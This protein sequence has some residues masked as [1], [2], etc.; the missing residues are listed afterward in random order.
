MKDTFLM[1]NFVLFI[2]S[3]LL[4]CSCIPNKKVVYFQDYGHSS[5][6]FDSLIRFNYPKYRLQKGDI[7][8]IDVRASDPTV[9]MIFDSNTNNN[10]VGQLAMGGADI[11]YLTGFPLNKN[12]DIELPL[13]GFV[14]VEGLSLE[15][16]KE[17]ISNELEKYIVEPYVIVRL[18]GIRYTALGEFRKPGRY[19]ILQSQLTIYE[20]LA[21]AGDL[22]I[23]ANRREVTIIRQYHDGQ[24]A[25]KI[26]LTDRNL[27]TSPFY[28]IQPN[29]QIYVEPLKVREIGAGVGVTGFG[30]ATSI[31]S[32]ISS[33][34]LI[35]VTLNN[36]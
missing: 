18:G 10:Q 5:V 7:L 2:I 19:A 14:K 28:Y 3:T 24:R 29:D 25:H 11:N 34:F 9:T 23:V 4:I 8:S 17:T 6:D 21:N 15:E 35:I 26:D 36:L 27:I 1:K 16:A 30:T 12:G 32:A 20:A 22:T 13:V 33:V 31:L